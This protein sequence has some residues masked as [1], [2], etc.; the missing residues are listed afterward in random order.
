[1]N[2]ETGRRIEGSLKRQ[3]IQAVGKKSDLHYLRRAICRRLCHPS[4]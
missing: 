3:M 2:T 4:A 1:L